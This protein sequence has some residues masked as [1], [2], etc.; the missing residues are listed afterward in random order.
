MLSKTNFSLKSSYITSSC[1]NTL[2]VCLPKPGKFDM[3][4]NLSTMSPVAFNSQ[5]ATGYYYDNTYHFT[6][7]NNSNLFHDMAT[8]CC[9][10]SALSIQEGSN[11]IVFDP[12]GVV[13]RFVIHS[14]CMYYLVYFV[15]FGSTDFLDKKSKR[16]CT[17]VLPCVGSPY[18]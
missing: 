15:S 16:Q 3:L 2:Y 4:F 5:F 6:T 9:Y 17:F 7:M 10:Q 1:K 14:D 18:P 8:T 12:E 11:N 13:L